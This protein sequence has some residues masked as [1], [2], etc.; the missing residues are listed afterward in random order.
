MEEN[1]KAVKVRDI[2]C[3]VHKPNFVYGYC[4]CG[5]EVSMDGDKICP[6]CGSALAWADADEL[7]KRE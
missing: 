5:R 1:Q 6:Y 2:H 7:L 3:S 4:A